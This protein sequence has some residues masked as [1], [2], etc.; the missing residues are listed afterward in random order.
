M[1]ETLERRWRPQIR[2]HGHWRDSLA[3]SRQVHV[4]SS[5][6]RW[7]VFA[8]VVN[9]PW[10][11]YALALSFLSVLLTTPKVCTQLGRPP[12]STQRDMSSVA[13]TPQDSIKG[14]KSGLLHRITRR[15][16]TEYPVGLFSD[17][18][19][20]NQLPALHTE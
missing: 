10:T 16:S 6:L 17:Q 7:L 15:W 4:S 8:L 11:P 2:K 13:T 9:V 3:S 18:T 14:I 5:G 20:L 19:F 12:Y 1:D